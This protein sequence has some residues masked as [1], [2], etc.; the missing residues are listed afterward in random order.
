MMVVVQVPSLRRPRLLE[1]R[2]IGST[3]SDPI[4]ALPLSL[5][6]H[7]RRSLSSPPTSINPRLASQ[8]LRA[9]ILAPRVA[10]PSHICYGSVLPDKSTHPFSSRVASQTTGDE[11]YLLPQL[12]TF[13]ESARVSSG[14]LL[15]PNSYNLPYV[16][17]SRRTPTR[18]DRRRG[19]SPMERAKSPS[20]LPQ[21][22]I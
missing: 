2:E 21:A 17:Q 18:R 3:H 19:V 20:W 4:R 9:S 14:S 6:F 5:V 13:S 7:R 12:E 15:S 16:Q 10:I 22:P 11:G 1:L 8:E